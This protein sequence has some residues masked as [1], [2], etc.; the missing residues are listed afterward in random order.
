MLRYTVVRALELSSVLL[1]VVSSVCGYED[2]C[3]LGGAGA[4][5]GGVRL[6]CGAR[7][8]RAL[9]F[10]HNIVFSKLTSLSILQPFPL[11]LSHKLN[12][13]DATVGGSD[14]FSN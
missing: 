8:N 7:Q 6:T 3:V 1:H 14:R 12:P 5:A 2:M 10:Y 9:G 11:S 4:A 13:I